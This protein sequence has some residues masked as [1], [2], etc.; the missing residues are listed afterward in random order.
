[1]LLPQVSSESSADATPVAVLLS[2]LLVGRLWARCMLGSDLKPGSITVVTDPGLL[3]A[4]IYRAISWTSA[5]YAVTRTRRWMS[6]LPNF[7]VKSWILAPSTPVCS[8]SAF[9]NKH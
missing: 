5:H 7:R 2:A 4:A 6:L 1:M 9:Q 8:K 3:G